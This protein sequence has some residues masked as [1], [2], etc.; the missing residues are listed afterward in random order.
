MSD[1]DKTLDNF[2]AHTG[3]SKVAVIIPLFGY[4]DNVE[5]NPLDLQT[6]QL[7][8]DR[9]N[10]SVHQIY[11]FFVGESKRLPKK[12]QNYILV[13]AK[14][15][16]NCQGVNLEEGAS[17]A[18]YVREGLAA[19]QRYTDSS[20][21]VVL[22][23]WNI[24]QRIG[25]DVM[26][27]RINYGDGAKI[28][29]GFNLRPEIKAD[30]FNPAEFEKLQFNLPVEKYKVDSNFMG[31]TRQF[32][33]M[34]P[35]DPK[36]KTAYFL[37]VD[38]FQNMHAQGFTAIASQRIPMFVFEVNVELLEDPLDLEEDKK[39]FISKWGFNPLM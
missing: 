25:I 7:T 31:M 26:V 5:D 19:A 27:D 32:L 24:I 13:H 14:A 38:M 17:Y 30:D 16:G 21:F 23:P 6:L 15:G 35:I 11:I 20:Y 3:K 29:S 28:I 12:I 1:L 2:I 22:N 34:T 10:S 37:E 9:I 39:Y 4:W 18:D 8:V 33:E 36:I